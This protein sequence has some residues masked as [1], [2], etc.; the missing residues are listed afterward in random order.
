MKT[1][2]FCLL[3]FFAF[4]ISTS[5]QA[6]DPHVHVSYRKELKT[7][8]VQT[9]WMYLINTEKQ[10]LQVGLITRY[11]G[12]RLEKPPKKIDLLIWS[13]SMPPLYRQATAPTLTIT[14]DGEAWNIPSRS[15]IVFTGETKNGQDIFWSEKRNAM[16]QPSVLPMGAFIKRR[17]GINGLYM[18]QIFFELSPE[19][20]AKM[21]RPAKLTMQLGQSNLEFSISYLTTL[22]DFSA[23]LVQGAQPMT[24]AKSDSTSSGEPENIGVVNGRA[25][26]LPRPEYPSMAKASRASGTVN[27]FVTI[28]E[29]GKVIAA[30]AISGHPLLQGASEAAAR[31]AR[32]SPTSV[33]GV[34]VKVSGIIVYNF[35]Q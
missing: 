22:R 28:D 21:A 35:M 8:V 15:Y 24:A 13:F 20:L 33:K 34:P 10:F 31:A 16:G 25:I 5:A 3:A 9:D 17:E 12:E 18:E 29:T 30:R 4:V 1:P 32:F 26:S 2:R 14:T 23:L 27:V 7:T 6:Q 19:Q 11:P